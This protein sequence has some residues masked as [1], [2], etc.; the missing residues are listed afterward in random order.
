MNDLDGRKRIAAIAEL[1]IVTAA[2]F[3]QSIALKARVDQSDYAAE[4]KEE[5]AVGDQYIQNGVRE[6]Y[7][8]EDGSYQVE[9]ASK[10]FG[11]DVILT[12]YVEQ[13]K[14]TL[15]GVEVVSQNETQEYGGRIVSEPELLK[16][17]EGVRLPVYTSQITDA[18]MDNGREEIT[19][20]M[21]LADGVYEREAANGDYTDQVVL[22]VEGGAI[23]A[24]TVDSYDKDGNYKSVLAAEGSYIMTEDGL[25]WDKQA[26]AV[27]AYVLEHQGVSGLDLGEDGKTDAIAGVSIS[28]GSIVD[29]IEECLLE[30]SGQEVS[31]AQTAPADG[32]L[33]DGIT[34]ATVTT[35]AVLSDINKAYVFLNGEE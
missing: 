7:L 3:G 8:L 25:T 21:I 27:A 16:Q 31:D 14:T 10:G 33:V 28:I 1:G 29:L 22:T 19:D 35:R 12:V 13:D 2:A 20:G 17:F 34:G 9:V 4:I 26:Q 24:V 11:G 23:T 32:T 5:L 18:G 30:A 15:R 6:A